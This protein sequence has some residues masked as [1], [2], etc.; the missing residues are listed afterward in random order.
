MYITQFA[1]YAV[2]HFLNLAVDF[3]MFV[4]VFVA[5]QK[6][7]DMLSD[8]GGG[9]NSSLALQTPIYCNGSGN[10]S[11]GDLDRNVK[12]ME[13]FEWCV[14]LLAGLGGAIFIAHL[15]ALIP[16]LCQYCANR[17][18]EQEIEDDQRYYQSII[19]IHSVFMLV[20]SIVHDIPSVILAVEL[21]VML[22][23]PS[24][25]WECALAPSGVKDLALDRST[26]WLALKITTV[27]F[28]SIYKGEDILVCFLGD[29]LFVLTH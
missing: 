8:T 11:L 20:E 29:C 13:I 9:G 10:F 24:N 17:D 2:L 15:C 5:N 27:A 7:D 3:G 19:C 14:M 25:C 6:C 21:C 4:D 16:N 12:P 1:V 26:M 23:N 22:F 28:A 18:F